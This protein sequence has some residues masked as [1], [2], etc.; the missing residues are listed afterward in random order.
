MRKEK[1][2]QVE[3]SKEKC[4]KMLA[5]L[6]N[7]LKVGQV[8]DALEAKGDKDAWKVMTEYTKEGSK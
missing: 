2:E 1:L 3:C 4:E 6:T 8:T 7:W 5:G